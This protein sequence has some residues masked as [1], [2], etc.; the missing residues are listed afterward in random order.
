M[1]STNMVD[2]PSLKQG[3]TNK[4]YYIIIRRLEYKTNAQNNV[5]ANLI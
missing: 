4:Y 3:K 1:V 5:W 2:L